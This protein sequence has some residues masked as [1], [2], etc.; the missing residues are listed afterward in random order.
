MKAYLLNAP[1][2]SGKDTIA[3]MMAESHINFIKMK[4][5]EPLYKAVQETFALTHTQWAA[6]YQ[7][8]KETPSEA[9]MGMTPRQAMI[10]FSEEVVKPKF[11]E[12]FYGN[13][14]ANRVKHLES[15]YRL[16]SA[17]LM[18]ADSGFADEARAVVEHLGGKNCYLI[19]L[20]REGSSFDND[21]RS[22]W[23]PADVG[24]S[25]DHHFTIDNNGS[26][27]DLREKF[28]EIIRL[29]E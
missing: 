23:N 22:Y 25:A 10:W 9:L 19:Q 11:G 18:F 14:A 4:F 12:D 6:M 5:A 20:T 13:L 27:C 15:D 24:M 3:D 8:A 26:L 1:A 17:T 21:S 16:S 29:V 28:E 7:N 2:R